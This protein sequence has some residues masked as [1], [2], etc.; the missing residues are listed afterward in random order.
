MPHAVRTA[1]SLA[2]VTLFI[3]G[4]SWNLNRNG[5]YSLLGAVE[6]ENLPLKK[7][8][9]RHIGLPVE[10]KAGFIGKVRLQV[11]VR[12]IRTASWVI[13]IEQLYLVAGPISLNEVYVER[14]SSL[15]RLSSTDEFAV[16]RRGGGAGGVGLQAESAGI[17]RSEVEGQHGPRCGLLRYQLQLLGGLRHLAGDEHHRESAAEHQG[18]PHKIRRWAGA[19]GW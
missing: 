10:I 18:R 12:Q 1:L 4:R 17:L 19:V 2:R 15:P 13:A 16:R 8:A 7:E 6:L 3:H 9:L 11:P 5:A 14:R